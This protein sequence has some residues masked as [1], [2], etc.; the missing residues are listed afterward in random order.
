MLLYIS[1]LLVVCRILFSTELLKDFRQA[2]HFVD[3]CHRSGAHRM[4]KGE[5][6]HSLLGTTIFSE[7]MVDSTSCE[8][9]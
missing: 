2:A 3:R 9:H 5:R 6:I 7:D 1:N 4:K 8:V